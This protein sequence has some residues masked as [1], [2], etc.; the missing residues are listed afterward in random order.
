VGFFLR[1]CVGERKKGLGK[2]VFFISGGGWAGDVRMLKEDL[3][4]KAAIQAQEGA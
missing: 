3:R 1:S 4:R 2:F